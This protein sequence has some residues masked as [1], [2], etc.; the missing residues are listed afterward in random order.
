MAVKE[1]GLGV[2]VLFERVFHGLLEA[3]FAPV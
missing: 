2:C 3:M 1:R